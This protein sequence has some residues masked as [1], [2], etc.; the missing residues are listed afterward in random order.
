[1]GTLRAENA[2][3]VQQIG[4]FEPQL[5]TPCEQLAGGAASSETEVLTDDR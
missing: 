4:R 2:A 3:N 1:M 5:L